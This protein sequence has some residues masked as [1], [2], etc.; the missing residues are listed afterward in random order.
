MTD[1]FLKGEKVRFTDAALHRMGPRFAD[2]I[3][4]VAGYR[5][6]AT[7][8]IVDFDRSGRRPAARLIGVRS[9]DLVRAAAL[10]P[11]EAE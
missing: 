2:R 11:K 10:T 4:T 3:G 5:L 6:G 8:P 7:D 9:R 1:E